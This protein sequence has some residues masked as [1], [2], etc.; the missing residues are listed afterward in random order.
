MARS[1]AF[2]WTAALGAGLLAAGIGYRPAAAADGPATSNGAAAPPRTVCVVNVK[3]V[4]EASP[5]FKAQSETLKGEMQ[6]KEADLQELQRK[7]KAATEM[8][9]KL[10]KKEDQEREDKSINDLQFEFASKQRKYREELSAQEADLMNQVYTEMADNLKRL[11]EHYNI[12][13]VVR[14]DE[15]D[16]STPADVKTMTLM[17]RQVVYYHPGIDLTPTLAKMMVPETAA[18]PGADRK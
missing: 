17:S 8:R 9:G 1:Q 7:L 15:P 3:K 13:I 14:L 5:R 11:C 16:A 10:T 6:K 18:A 4:F 2:G 12:M